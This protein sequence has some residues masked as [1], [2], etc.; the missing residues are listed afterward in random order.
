MRQTVEEKVVMGDFAV[1]IL[2]LALEAKFPMYA[3]SN[4]TLQQQNIFRAEK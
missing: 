4:Y 1:F 2:F 3:E